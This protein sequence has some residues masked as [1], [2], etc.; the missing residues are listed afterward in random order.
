[1]AEWRRIEVPSSVARAW[2]GW[3]E[4]LGPSSARR[5]AIFLEDREA[6]AG[7][8]LAAC[9]LGRQVV[10][11]GDAL[12]ATVDALRPEVDAFVGDFPGV[13]VLRAQ[14][15]D[16]AE[17]LVTVDPEA[18]RLTVFTS[19]STG[20]P[21]AIPRRLS[22]LL[23][24]V[25]ALEAAFGARVPARARF[26][27]TVSHQHLYGLLFAV[28]WPLVTGRR[29][30]AARVEYPETVR[31]ELAAADAA[32]VT[33]PAYLKRLPAGEPWQTNVR[34][35]FSSGGP[36][37]DE[38]ARE[39]E[40]MLGLAP[41]DVYGSS[42]TGGIAWRT[43][44][45]RSWQPLPGVRFRIGE[46]GRLEVHSPFVG[47][48]GWYPTADLASPAG[49]SFVLQGRADRIVKVEDKR[50]SL[51]AAERALVNG[52]LCNEARV[53]VLEGRRT[54]LGA[55]CVL[56]PRGAELAASGR[57]ALVARLRDGLKAVLEPGAVPRR[58]RF[59]DQ[60]PVNEQG[61]VTE[62]ALRAL[63][64]PER[65]L[66]SW[67]TRS[68]RQ[69]A[70]SFTV[71]PTLRVLDGHFPSHP[72]V[73]GIAQVDWALWFAAQAFPLPGTPRVVEALKFQAL[74]RPGAVV[75]LALDWDPERATLRFRFSD[76]ARAYS[77]GRFRFG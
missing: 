10:I 52:G 64:A 9:S 59:V 27:S 1:M 24:E 48:E 14:A 22:Q 17:R 51:D 33:S 13:T 40:R 42:E 56:S 3:R 11:P 28:L 53:V 37:A 35:V 75:T 73:P 68:E 16:C 46:S 8:L 76:A 23:A 47:T 25:E 5:I 61:K 70:L 57:N 54:E 55:V 29:L 72:I 65:P 69:A 26:V 67:T 31:G 21:A 58:F 41:I 36:L 2:A 34:A 49:D 50:V 74:M 38:T 32:L 4:V 20:I 45:H 43:Y 66:A 44:H 63:F 62:R 39:A 30:T 71:E 7:A 18:S 60:L 19:G 12:P 6:F 15:V 77:S